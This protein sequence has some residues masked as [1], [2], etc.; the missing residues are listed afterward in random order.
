MHLS[1]SIYCFTITKKNLYC[2]FELSI[3]D[4]SLQLLSKSR[5]SER[6]SIEILKQIQS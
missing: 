5:A 2:I 4:T 1:E 3:G 6:H